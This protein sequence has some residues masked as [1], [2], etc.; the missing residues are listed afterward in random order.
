MLKTS[1]KVK[2]LCSLLFNF[3][4]NISFLFIF[5]LTSIK[6]SPKSEDISFTYDMRTAKSTFK[7]GFELEE[8]ATHAS[9][10]NSEILLFF[11]D[12]LGPAMGSWN[13]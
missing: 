5:K 11:L 12:P 6:P 10:L 7:F 13:N 8:S 2:I 3:L 1:L 9:S 4:S